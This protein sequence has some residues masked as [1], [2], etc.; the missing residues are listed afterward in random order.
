M[1]GIW[2]LCFF[3]VGYV[4]VRNDLWAHAHGQSVVPS[5]W[6]GSLGAYRVAA[7]C[8]DVWQKRKRTSLRAVEKAYLVDMAG[9]G[10]SI[11]VS[12]DEEAQDGR[13][14]LGAFADLEAC[15]DSRMSF[16]EAGFAGIFPTESIDG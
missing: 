6:F 12:R 9:G 8:S 11:A 5:R 15:R 3:I 13:Q 7:L 10:G 2:G 16:L 14:A 1:M 4:L